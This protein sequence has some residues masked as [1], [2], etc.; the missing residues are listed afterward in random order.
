M[1]GKDFQAPMENFSRSSSA[2]WDPRYGNRFFDPFRDLT[3][4]RIL[5]RYSAYNP[6]GQ[7]NWSGF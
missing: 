5:S 7:D 2:H 4:F 1:Y 3:A 6:D